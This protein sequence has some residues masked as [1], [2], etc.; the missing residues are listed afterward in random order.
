MS[1]AERRIDGNLIPRQLP[2]EYHSSPIQTQMT[3]MYMFSRFFPQ[4]AL[5]LAIAGS[6]FA[7]PLVASSAPH[8]AL[9]DPPS[10][11]KHLRAELQS[12]DATRVHNALVDV[13][14]LA[15]CTGSCNVTLQSA[16][17]KRIRIEN[18]AGLGTVL[19]LSILGAD[20]ATA[21]RS[22]PADG[23]RLL[24]LSALIN[25]GNDEA[26]AQVLEADESPQSEKVNRV[27][28]RS[29]A[30]YY[31]TKY[32]E[33]AERAKRKKTFSIE[34]VQRAEAVRVKL[35]KKESKN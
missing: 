14:S 18:E 12:E 19:D 30:S 24:A 22:G 23:H 27:T 33:L 13:I 31:L 21:Y 35:A 2:A 15:S 26:I 34:D 10:L 11:V 28:Q 25:I 7:G 17:K 3:P 4:L 32:P 16:Q 8:L 5:V 9:T 29:L 20:L 6:L 1:E